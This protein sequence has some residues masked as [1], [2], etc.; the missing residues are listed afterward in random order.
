MPEAVDTNP[1]LDAAM[2]QLDRDWSRDTKA[3]RA[4][5]LV[6]AGDLRLVLDS[7]ADY[8]ARRATGGP[9]PP[10]THSWRNADSRPET[11]P[12]ASGV[13]PVGC[14]RLCGRCTQIAQEG[15]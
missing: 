15:T 8:R 3:L 5:V 6:Q 14:P 9:P 11:A 2:A 10:F 1:D 4:A 7:L 13:C 12:A